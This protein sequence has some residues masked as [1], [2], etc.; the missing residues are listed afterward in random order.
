MT[1]ATNPSEEKIQKLMALGFGREEC[2]RALQIAGGNEDVAASF[3]FN[4]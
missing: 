1:P 4:M 3:L 2:Q